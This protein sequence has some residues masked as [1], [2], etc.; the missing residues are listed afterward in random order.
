[1]EEN[2]NDNSFKNVVFETD[3][4]HRKTNSAGFGKTVILPFFC[5]ILGAGIVIRR[6]HWYSIY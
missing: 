5:G 3:N 1:M 2:N 4:K 6:M